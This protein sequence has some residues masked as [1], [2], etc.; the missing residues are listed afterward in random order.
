M[1]AQALTNFLWGLLWSGL[2]RESGSG[3][4]ELENVDDFEDAENFRQGACLM[5]PQGQGKP[6]NQNEMLLEE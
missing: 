6:W 2:A 3:N 1:R 5:K 4:A